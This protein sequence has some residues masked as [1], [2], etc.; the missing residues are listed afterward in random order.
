MQHWLAVGAVVL[1]FL[2]GAQTTG[3]VS[4][5]DGSHL[6]LARA[7][8]L[9]GETSIDPEMALTLR[10]DL[11]RRGDH[12]YSD[13]PPGTAFAALP[14]VVVGAALD[15]W[16]LELGRRRGELVVRPA[17]ERYLFTYVERVEGAAPL[18]GYMGTALALAVHTVGLGL[19]GLWIVDRL[20]RR[21]GAGE[22]ARA[23]ALAALGLGSL[24][25]PYSTLLFSHVGAATAV[26][27]TWLGI[28]VLR[29]PGARGAAAAAVGA[30]GATAVACDYA[31]LAAIVPLVIA[32]VSPRRWLLVLAGAAPVVVAT[33]GYH[34]AAFGDPFAIGYHF[35]TNFAFARDARDTF[36]GNLLQGAWV[37]LGFGH[38]GAGLAAQSPVLAVGALGWLVAAPLD[39]RLVLAFLPWLA[40]VCLHETPEGGATGDHRYILPLLPA[41]AWGLARTWERWLT[42]RRWLQVAAVAL[43]FASAVV[44]WRHFLGWHEASPFAS[45]GVGS[46]LA[47]G[48]AAWLAIAHRIRARRAAAR[49]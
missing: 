42:G 22:S 32:G 39:R 23:F 2:W 18:A 45:V 27:G 9:R 14:A 20:L 44:T 31:L 41:F 36:D 48:L 5:N 8:A 6:A 37:L 34:Q 4:S 47:L 49:T 11:A 35:H 10:V 38:A 26:A 1:A 19:L 28:V 12:Y 29:E 13:R 17:T 16:V 25:G 15:P 24:W 46:G 21:T 33:L 30:C 43:L 40:L 3:I 7:L